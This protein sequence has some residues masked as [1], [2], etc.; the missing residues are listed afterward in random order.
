MQPDRELGALVDVRL[1]PVTFRRTY[2]FATDR[3][4]MTS[5]ST[6]RFREREEV[7]ADLVTRATRLRRCATRWTGRAGRSC[8]SPDARRTTEGAGRLPDTRPPSERGA[9]GRNDT[10]NGPTDHTAGP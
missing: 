5:Q 4:T 9:A 8:S 2:V 7:E 1:P 3:Q 6:L 10:N